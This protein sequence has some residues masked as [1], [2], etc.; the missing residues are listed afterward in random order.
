MSVVIAIT[1][2]SG[3]IGR[4]LAEN[5]AAK[6]NTAGTKYKLMLIARRETELAAAVTTCN[7]LAGEPCAAMCVGDMTK[8]PDV[9]AALA[10]TVKAFGRVDV[11]INNVGRGIAKPTLDITDAD[12]DDMMNVNVK[13]ALHGMQL[14]VARFLEQGRPATG[15]I[16]NVSSIL[17]RNAELAPIRSAYSGSKYF[18]NALTDSLRCDLNASDETKGIT[19]STVSPGPVATDFGINANGPDSRANPD[20]Q[21]VDEVAAVLREV[22]ES[23]AT[24]AYTRP[25]HKAAIVKHIADKG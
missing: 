11:W 8:R 18:L 17:G 1:G 20:A 4:A 10:A 6:P 15:H 7:E 14:A 16:I 12:I 3:G 13:S 24:D 9:E 5:L 19:L 23:R 2:A 25:G 21:P 22:I